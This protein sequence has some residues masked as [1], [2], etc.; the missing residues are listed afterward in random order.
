[1]RTKRW[2]VRVPACKDELLRFDV[3]VW[4]VG[5]LLSKTH[6]VYARDIGDI[7]NQTT[8]TSLCKRGRLERRRIRLRGTLRH[9]SEKM[10]K[11]VQICA[12]IL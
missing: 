3:H 6:S 11:K 1:M 7:G 5:R 10:I 2:T 8:Y 9:F 12:K 4:D